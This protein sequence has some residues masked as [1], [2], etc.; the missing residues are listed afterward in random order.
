[1]YDGGV[2]YTTDAGNLWVSSNAGIGTN[3]MISDI[4]FDPLRPEVIYASS[5]SSGVFMSENSGQTW[6]NINDG[7]LNRFVRSL[8][9]SSDGE[10]LYAA[11]NGAG[12]FRLSTL[13][14]ADFDALTPQDLVDAAAEPSGIV[15][16]VDIV[17]DGNGEKD[18]Y[19]R[20]EAALN[21][22]PANDSGDYLDLTEIYAFSTDEAIYFLVEYNPGTKEFV[23]MDFIFETLESEIYRAIYEPVLGVKSWI[24]NQTVGWEEIGFTQHS[25]VYL[26][27]AIE[28][29]IDFRDLGVA[30]GEI[31]GA[32]LLR[33]DVHI[34]D[35]ANWVPAE[36]WE[37]SQSTYQK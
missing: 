36:S 10:T 29:R 19:G 32:H 21:A 4:V 2:Y 17:L 37:S 35:E 3:E 1:M 12:L 6:A 9:I 20:T 14:Q 22:D 28:G 16:E 26:G 31:K 8:A 33:V 25:T 11:V 34:G 18:W 30:E 15:E 27:D 24:V 23:Q 7:L 13:D 5:W